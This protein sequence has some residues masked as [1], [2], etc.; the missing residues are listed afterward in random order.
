MVQW[1]DNQFFYNKCKFYNINTFKISSSL[2]FLIANDYRAKEA[3]FFRQIYP[4]EKMGY[5]CAEQELRELFE[6]S[7]RNGI[8]LLQ[9]YFK[10][11]NI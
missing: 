6:K 9:K 11:N 4:A 5:E 8:S 1:I 7:R 2:I 3:Q 10:I